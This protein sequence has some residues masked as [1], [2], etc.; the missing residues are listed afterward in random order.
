MAIQDLLGTDI[1]GLVNNPWFI[2]FLIV[3][4]AWK[5]AWYGAALW[6]TIQ[7]KKMTHFIVLFA[8]MSVLNDLGIVPIIY[9]L[10]NKNKS[11]K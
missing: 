8:L 2:A 5:F 4:T 10:Y 3:V 6:Q 11:K 7:K 1:G 9:L